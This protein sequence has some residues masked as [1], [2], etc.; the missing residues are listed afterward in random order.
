[1]LTLY[2]QSD[3]VCSSGLTF[4]DLDTGEITTLQLEGTT[5]T[6]QVRVNRHYNI[7]VTASNSVGS[8]TSS[9]TLSECPYILYIVLLY[10]CIVSIGTHDILNA[11]TT[12]TDD[13][14]IV[15]TTLYSE[16]SDARGALFDFVFIDDNG[17]VDLTRSVLLALDR[18]TSFH[19]TLPF[20]LYPG[21]Y[22]VFVYDIES[23]GTLS[24]G[25]GYPAVTD[26]LVL[27]LSN[28]NHSQGISIPPSPS[29]AHVIPI[30]VTDIPDTSNCQITYCSG[31]IR[32]ECNDTSD[33]QIVAQS[34][35]SN[36]IHVNQ[37]MDFQTPVTVEVE[38][39]GVYQVTI[40]GILDSNGTHVEYV[41]S[42]P[43]TI[44][45]CTTTTSG[46]CVYVR[47]WCKRKIVLAKRLEM[48]FIRRSL[49][50]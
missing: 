50:A 46:V 12:E 34:R 4:V 23:D 42:T 29:P 32:A 44:S 7:T 49:Q 45:T 10:Y 37:S 35:N 33:F 19:H 2:V 14:A 21:Q 22:R 17:D 31:V 36:K 20:N 27:M 43:I 40:L 18:N 26:E 24:N 1:M 3:P 6:T 25:V 39:S 8:D 9:I 5:F 30:L 15:I 28:G 38:E 48:S 13:D 11:T 41:K 47:V 16:H